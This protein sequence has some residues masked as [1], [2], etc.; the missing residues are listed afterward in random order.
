MRGGGR[1]LPGGAWRGGGDVGGVEGGPPGRWFDRLYWN[2]PWKGLEKNLDGRG[3]GGPPGRWFDRGLREDRRGGGPTDSTSSPVEGL[4]PAYFVL[5]LS[6]STSGSP[7]P[8]CS[9]MLPR[10]S[11]GRSRHLQGTFPSPLFV[12]YNI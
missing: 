9:A 3:E 6:P 12:C 1:S 4:S 7:P 8:H 10:T 5:E 11:S 2:L